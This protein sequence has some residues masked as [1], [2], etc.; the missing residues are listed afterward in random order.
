ML[1]QRLLIANRGE[2]TVRIARTCRELGIATVGV[3]SDA[4]ED[5][6][7]VEAVD[8]AVRLPGV[9]SAE[10]YLDMD[11]LLAAAERTGADAVHPG[12]G[13]LAENAEFAQ[14]VLD[15]GLIWVGPDPDA[16][17]AMGDKVEAKRRMADAGVPLLPSIPVDDD[18]DLQAAG[19]EVGFPLMVKASAGGGGKGMRIVESAEGL[20]DA[21]GAARREAS[22]AFGDDRVFLERYLERPRHIEIQVLA[23]THGNVL[24][25]LERECSIQRRHQKVVEEA[26]SPAVDADLRAELGAA[27]VAAAK[28]IGYV[29][30]G[31][32]E[33][34]A[35]TDD[36]GG[37]TDFSFLEMNTRLQVE[38]PVTE[39]ITGHDLVALQL[40]VAGGEA[41]PISQNDV[42]ADGHAIEVRLYAED[43]AGGYLPA[44][45]TVELF[46]PDLAA[47]VRWDSGIAEG[48]VIS[49]HYD[50]MV[51][52]VIAHAD[53]RE[54]AA[55]QLAAAL[56]ASGIGGIT[57]NR[58]LLV[59]ILRDDA[60]LAG[61]TTTAY[62]DERF[63]DPAE[64]VAAS[65]AELE[66]LAAAIATARSAVA[67][68]EQA[69]VNA[70]IPPGFTN[71]P[72]ARWFASFRGSEGAIEVHY[73]YGRD[74]AFR[75]EIG[76]T[77][78]RVTV[79]E[80]E[81]VEVDGRRTQVR[82]FLRGTTHHLLFAHRHLAIEEIPRFPER[83]VEDVAGATR[84]PMPGAVVAVA[85]EE[86][87]EVETG[88]LLVALEAMKME[89]KITA[90][91][92]GTVTEVAVS[93]GDQVDSDA[94]LVV[95]EEATD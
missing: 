71:D 72:H 54:D 76:D 25:L 80:D 66:R 43:P 6:L 9:T 46:R 65:D 93:E 34:I 50:P 74:G 41:L 26:P 20:A 22:G 11:A 16:I 73:R 62:L 17:A 8:E 39:A 47:G 88:D 92:D 68:Q 18:T 90:P 81:V 94:M 89:H 59:A 67:R 19:E 79:L 42:E 3:F 29:N 32:V 84:A 35:A 38:H 21:V 48:G 37:I 64:R 86:G 63:P 15:A 78:H 51:A 83:T 24:H 2:I 33:F 87:D 95:V 44:T 69:S 27:A 31:T 23:D 82:W 52:K 28:A 61:D 56:E 75:T 13:F 77:T 10:T 45:G 85:V 70:T 58:D 57:T 14:R 55:T 7:H 12:Y 60:F 53:R 1:I 91:F 30:A 36:D 49:S 4:D 5:A 40:L